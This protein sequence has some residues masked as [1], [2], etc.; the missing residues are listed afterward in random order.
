MISSLQD[1]PAAAPARRW[2]SSMGGPPHCRSLRRS[3]APLVDKLRVALKEDRHH[4]GRDSHPVEVRLRAL[5]DL[6]VAHV[7]AGH[8]GEE[9]EA[10]VS[11][12]LVQLQQVRD[13]QHDSSVV[14]DPPDVDE[15]RLLR[16]ILLVVTGGKGV[17]F[18][19]QQG[20]A[21]V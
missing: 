1:P 4:L 6:V 15:L 18:Q 3:H 5:L 20:L 9:A 13:Q 12:T 2:S 7:A 21:A 14:D 11:P 16:G 17:T 8:D 19:H 10:T